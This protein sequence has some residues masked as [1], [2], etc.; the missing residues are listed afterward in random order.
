MRDLHP[1]LE[2]RKTADAILERDD[3]AIRDDCL[4]GLM[5]EGS[6]SSG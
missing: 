2:H 5:P 3:L 1:L 6:T 4:R